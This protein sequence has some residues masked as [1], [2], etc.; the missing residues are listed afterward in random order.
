MIE[1]NLLPL[2]ILEKKKQEWKK[3]IPLLTLLLIVSLSSGIAAA[4]WWQIHLL[5][6]KIYE[7]NNQLAVNGVLQSEL[8][9]W[10]KQKKRI[11]QMA[12]IKKNLQVE[13]V[14]TNFL[15]DQI[16]LLLPTDMCFTKV[17]TKGKQ[18]HIEGLSLSYESLAIF[19]NNLN[20]SHYFSSDPILEKSNVTTL[21]GNVQA[22]PIS[23][24]I[25]GTFTTEEVRIIEPIPTNQ[26][27][28]KR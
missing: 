21:E 2:E 1:I 18:L 16:T 25:K 4:K 15:L 12:Q 24:L 6:Q 13:K 10:Q 22:S 17:I 3:V 14:Q 11:E 20:A 27:N 7:V 5:E 26:D 23:F 28:R 19:L 8:Q 9:A